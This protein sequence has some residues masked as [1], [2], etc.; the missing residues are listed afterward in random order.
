MRAQ[1]AS[2]IRANFKLSRAMLR[3]PTATSCYITTRLRQRQGAGRLC[4]QSGS[5]HAHQRPAIHDRRAAVAS[6]CSRRAADTIPKNVSKDTFL[7]LRLGAIRYYREVG[8]F[9][10]G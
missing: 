4:P 9:N 1:V 10:F 8:I 6:G 7:P 3:L 2:A 5:R